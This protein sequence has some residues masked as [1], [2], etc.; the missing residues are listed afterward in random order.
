MGP[1]V[2]IVGVY[3]FFFNFALSINM[4]IDFFLFTT[5]YGRSPC[6][7]WVLEIR[8]GTGD[9]ICKQ[10]HCFLFYILLRFIITFVT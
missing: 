5:M 2:G 8:K 4:R 10:S 9:V 1:F 6:S 7:C 3:K